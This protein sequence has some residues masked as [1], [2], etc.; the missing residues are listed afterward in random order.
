MTGVAN[1]QGTRGAHSSKFKPRFH[2]PDPLPSVSEFRLDHILA[3]ALHQESTQVC[4]SLIKVSGNYQQDLKREIRKALAIEQK[5]QNKNIHAIKRA[6]KLTKQ[7]QNTRKEFSR[8]M[9]SAGENRKICKV[10]KRGNTAL[11]SDIDSLLTQSIDVSGHVKSLAVRMAQLS[12]KRG[13][14]GKPD[15]AKCP[16]L[17]RLLNSLDPPDSLDPNQSQ[18]EPNGTKLDVPLEGSLPKEGTENGMEEAAPKNEHTESVKGV[19]GELIEP[20]TDSQ[21]GN[22]QPF[23]K[24][25]IHVGTSQ[26]FSQKDA[27]QNSPKAHI[28]NALQA[29][30]NTD[31]RES[32]FLEGSSSAG[33]ENGNFSPV[34]DD[35]V[36]DTDA[37]ELFMDTSIA[38]YRERKDERSRSL[39][40]F[41]LEKNGSLRK[42]ARNPLRL[43][44]S[45]SLASGQSIK[46]SPYIEQDDPLKYS[47]LPRK[48][49]A[50]VLETPELSL[51]KKLRIKV[52][53]SPAKSPKENDAC[54]CQ[55][56]DP[57]ISSEQDEFAKSGEPSDT[58]KTHNIT[59]DAAKTQNPNED[60]WSSSEAPTEAES[61]S[62]NSMA[63]S[64][65]DESSSDSNDGHI[66]E[67]NSYYVSLRSQM[68]RKSRKKQKNTTDLAYLKEPSPSRKHQPSHRVLQPKQSILKLGKAKT[69]N[70]GARAEIAEIVNNEESQYMASPRASFVNENS[71]VGMILN[72]SKD[73]GKS[74]KDDTSEGS[75]GRKSDQ[76]FSRGS[77]DSASPNQPSS[78]EGKEDMSQA[79]GKLRSFII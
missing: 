40:S 45:G 1:S 28:G 42:S 2:N 75:D 55:Q 33:H 7:W 62:D 63:S 69:S 65:S 77:S 6:H 71:V 46:S 58:N 60:V 38:K 8:N 5:I 4:E 30:R 50:T 70:S 67:T 68:K 78:S 14:N 32:D 64:S 19:K 79:M 29:V 47:F 20:I 12:R 13:G 27:S 56:T 21:D 16:N 66:S 43:L 11:G 17:N 54:I 61:S 57:E 37:F 26:A 48:S 15:Q 51:H 52:L 31:N 18:N 24:A 59:E 10:N 23:Q 73:T 72:V 76:K 22:S 3:K 44:S 35:T 41:S 25:D 74:P 49:A 34:N 9:V 36:M 39:S 53:P